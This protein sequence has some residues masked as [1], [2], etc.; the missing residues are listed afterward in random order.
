MI[1]VGI[2]GGTGYTAGELI[3]ILFYHPKVIIQN[4][5]SFSQPGKFVYKTHHDL[6]GITDMKFVN[7]LDENLDIIFLCLNHGS[8]QKILKSISRETKIIDLSQDFRLNH[9]STINGRYFIY[10]LPEQERNNIKNSNS[11]ANP[12]CFATAIQL[13][14]LPLVYT[15]NLKGDIHISAITGS[16]GAGKKLNET[17]HFSWR[18]NNISNYNVFTHQHVYEIKEGIIRGIGKSF[19]GEIYFVP[20]RGNFSRGIIATVYINSSLTFEEYKI[21]YNNYYKTHP[22]VYISNQNIY[23][24]QVINTNNCFLHLSQQKNKFIITSIIDNLLKGA[25][26]QAVQNLNL[27][28]NLEENCGLRLKPIGF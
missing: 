5:L 12:G 16:T 19:Q 14:L 6:L 28:F 7:S 22:F 3:K 27:M 18:N 10:G 9:Q 2:I 4:I 11:I 1:K 20:Y 25:S 24:K 26:G 8:S 21:I 23:L 15:K 13:A 17:S